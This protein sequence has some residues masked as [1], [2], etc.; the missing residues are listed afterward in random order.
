[1]HTYVIYDIVEDLPQPDVVLSHF[2]SRESYAEFVKGYSVTDRKFIEH[3]VL[4]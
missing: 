4:D 2:P 1:M 3:L